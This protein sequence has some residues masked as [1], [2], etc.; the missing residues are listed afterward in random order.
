VLESGQPLLVTVDVRAEG[1]NF[2]LTAQ[3][4]EALD[5][6]VAQAAAGMKVVLV[7]AGALE[8]LRNLMRGEAGGRGRVSVVV[9]I[10]AREVEIAL[11]GGFKISPKVIGSAQALPG[12]L[13]VQEI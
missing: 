2:R 10:E 5:R 6:I 1:D 9:P 13:A 11:P 12:I 4:L 8:P 3:K 7:E